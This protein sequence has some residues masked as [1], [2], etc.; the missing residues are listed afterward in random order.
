[1][2]SQIIRVSKSC[3]FLCLTCLRG[4]MN[5]PF[6]TSIKHKLQRQPIP[7]TN[8][9]TAGLVR[10]RVPMASNR[11]FENLNIQ[12][13][14]WDNGQ[15]SDIWSISPA[16]PDFYKIPVPS[17]LQFLS[18]DKAFHSLCTSKSVDLNDL[19]AQSIS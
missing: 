13:C 16:P 3:F 11:L 7:I 1:M 19:L 5:S 6:A 18:P 15:S 10:A 2:M 9:G 8:S 4:G 12:W 17:S 14:I